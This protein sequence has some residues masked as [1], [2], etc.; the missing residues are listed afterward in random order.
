MGLYSSSL[1]GFM[2]GALT[3]EIAGTRILAD[4]LN[5]HPAFSAT[6]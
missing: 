6:K 2:I 3:L 1:P 5:D 4:A